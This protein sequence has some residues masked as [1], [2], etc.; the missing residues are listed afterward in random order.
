VVD[1]DG[2]RRVVVEP[3]TGHPYPHHELLPGSQGLD[4]GQLTSRCPDTTPELF[5]LWRR[6]RATAHELKQTPS[7][8][9]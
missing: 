5:R 3:P 9:R 1:P 8:S 6:N 2:P 7:G 4:Q